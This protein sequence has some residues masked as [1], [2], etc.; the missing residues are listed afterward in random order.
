M[1]F[2]FRLNNFL[3]NISMLIII[4]GFFS[5]SSAQLTGT[6]TIPGDY[7]T[8]Q[9]A[10]ADLN[11]QGV[12]LGGVTFDVAAGHTETF[13]TD[14]AGNIFATGTLG[15][16]I[17]FQKSGV[18]NNPLITASGL[19]TISTSTS[20]TA[21]GDGII[22]IEG[23]DYITFDGIDLQENILATGNQFMEVGY[24]LK[25]ASG[26]DACKNVTI[27]NCNISLDQA[28]RY[29]YGIYV[30]NLFGSSTVTVTSIGGRSEDIKIY[31]N[32]IS[33]VYV[34]IHTRGYAAS[35]PYDLYD[36]NIEIGV[37][38]GNTITNF[39][40][41]ASTAYGM[42]SI[43]Q[44]NLKIANNT[45]NGG[46]G[47]TTTL[48]GIFNSTGTNS[49]LDVYGNTITVEGG[50]TT[51]S[52]Y[53]LSSSMGS[54]GTDNTVNIYDN[55][56]E[57]ST[58]PTAT[59]GA[60]YCLYNSASA[61][62]VNMYGNTVRNNVKDGTSG[63]MYLLYNLSTGAGGFANIYDNEIY[64][65]T[66]N[67]TG[68]LYCLYSNE[69][70]T[71]T[72]M[73]YGN[74]I[75]A[76]TG[77]GDVIGIFSAT[78]VLAHIYNNDIYDLTST[79]T[80]TASPYATGIQVSTGTDI[81]VYNNFISDLK[82]PAAEA[83]D[84][85]RGIGFTSATANATRNA[86]YNTVFLNASSTGVNFGSSGIFHIYSATAT[87]STLD[88]RNNNI[89]NSSTA[90]G[91]GVT[92]AFRRS[93]ATSLDNYSELSNNNNFYGGTPGVSNLLYYDGT[94]S[95]Q[96]IGDLQLLVGPRETASVSGNPPFV[97]TTTTPYDLHISTTTPTQL[98]SAG[99][100]ITSPIAVSTD[101][102]GDTRDAVFPDI[103]ADE[104]NGIGADLTS[105]SIT[106]D[107]LS[108]TANTTSVSLTATITDASG[109]ATGS[110]APRLYIK[111]STDLS[112]VF[113]D[114]PLVVG[115]D[116]T[117]T[118][119]YT[120]LGG[121]A[122][123]DVIEYYV[124]AQDVPG[125]VG[126]NPAGGSGANPPGTVPP[127][128][129][130]SYQIVD[131]PLN[132]TFTVG[133]NLFNQLTGKE[134][135]FETRTRTVTRD[136]NGIDGYV[137]V[138][139]PADEKSGVANLNNSP[140][141]VT[142]TE[143]YKVMMENG[144]PFDT[145][146]FLSPES[147]GVY[148]TITAAVN[149]LV[150]RGV[151]G[152][153]TFSLVDTDYPNETYPIDL[154]S[155][156]GASP[157]N[158]VTFK[159]ATGIQATIPGDSTQA[160]AT[161]RFNTSGYYYIIDGSNTVGGTSRDLTISVGGTA[162]SPAVHFYSDG[163]NN[164]V[165]NCIIESQNTSTGSG[166][167][168]LAAGDGSSNNVIDNCLF[169]PIDGASAYGIGV[170]MFSTTTS[171]NNTISNCE[172]VD[173]ADRGITM[174]GGVGV[175]NNQALYNTIY[176]TMP[177]SKTTIYGIY[178]GRGPDNIIEGN[179]IT[180]LQSSTSSP[181][182]AGIYYI[183]SSGVDMTVRVVNNVIAI[184][185]DANL[186]AGTIRGIDYF[187]YSAN[188]IEIYY[189]TVLIG[190]TDVTT[191]T[192]GAVNKRDAANNF[193]VKNNSFY[194]SRSNSSGTGIHYAVQF[195]NS[196]AT[197]FDLNNNDYYTSGTGGILGRWGTT[198]VL[199]LVDWQIATTMDA[200]SISADPLYSSNSDLRPQL[201]SPL[202]GAGV[203]VAGITT[204]V[205][206]VLRDIT[207]PTIGAYEEGIV[208]PLAGDYTVGLSL[209]RSLS[210]KDITFEKRV[211]TIQIEETIID[212]VK[213][214]QV[215][216]YEETVKG[217][218]TLQEPADA[219]DLMPVTVTRTVE[220]EYYVP[221]LNG[222]EYNG[223]LYYEFTAE[224]K[225]V[226]N[227]ESRGVYATITDA[228]ADATLKGVG[229]PVNFILVDATYPSETFPIV[230]GEIAGVSST[231]TITLRPNVGVTS[232]VSGTINMPIFDFVGASYFIIDGRSGGV[233]ED[234]ALTVENLSTVSGSHT[235]RLGGGSTFNTIRY[236]EIINSSQGTA[237]PR[238]IDIPTSPVNPLGNSFNTIEYNY[239]SGGRT[240]IGFAGTT[241]NPNTDNIIM[242][243]TLTDFAF[244]GIWFSSNTANTTVEGNTLFHTV[245][246]A[247]SGT[248]ISVGASANQGVTNIVGNHFYDL[249]HTGTGTLRGI[250][251]T[252]G[253]GSTFNLIN[254]FFSFT[255]DNG[256]K[257]SIYAVQLSGSTEYTV[258][259]YYNTFR[260]GGVH[261]GGSAGTI[262]T[263]GLVKSST[264][265]PA[266]F[267]AKNNIGL[268]ER[269]GGVEGGFHTNFFAGSTNLVG[270][271]D[272]DYN[273]W[274][275]EGDT[276]RSFSSGWA[277]FLYNDITDYKTAA[278]PHEQNTIFKTTEFVSLTDLH[279]AGNSVG[280]FDLI[281]YPIVGI[282]T[283]IDGQ[284][285][286][287]N[288][289]YRGADEGD[290]PLPVE[291]TSFAGAVSGNAVSLT[292]STATEI[293]NSG[294]E[295]QRK[296]DQGWEKIGFVD[297][298]GTTTELN[299]YSF[300][301][302]YEYVSF[303]GTASYRLKQIDF[304]GTF[305]YSSP[306]EVDVDFTPKDYTLY[307]NYPNPFN[308]STTIKYALPFDS[309][310]KIFIYNILGEVV[311]EL[312]NTV[313]GVGYHEVVL[314]AT[315]LA[316]GVYIYSIQAK[317]VD[318]G[319]D[320]SSVKKMMYLK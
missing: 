205:L 41:G 55:I 167:L 38:G 245:G 211:R 256:T 162:T 28:T 275:A 198:D 220:Q 47:T 255:Q 312:V 106:Y 50:A 241:A 149:D 185:A 254:N 53:G 37:D 152:P 304:D 52:I 202:I 123:G 7:A 317:S 298:K 122:I 129:P 76:N 124:A 228:I 302:K 262:V 58:Y 148:P 151:D 130:N 25:K 214:E 320:F 217:T 139:A 175:M 54:S 248:G 15:N 178:Q 177:S 45:I 144:K 263:A 115:D 5:L 160:A 138:N 166:S 17:I 203:P 272:I 267:N 236:T 145:N 18:G 133:L 114:S 308:P 65:N 204:D 83:T 91:T 23:G 8:I 176:Q 156:V 59:S 136:F 146:F 63:S 11:T 159:P 233:G 224:Q 20:L 206:G 287:I 108:N 154:T 187:G 318:G 295:V 86:Y 40:G 188:S 319:K 259:A 116:Y 161:I 104:F 43:Y 51:S 89:V 107:F 190:G 216:I 181:T 293:N 164:V 265:D 30:S 219:A 261:T 242:G 119:A 291:L 132:G 201:G 301:D 153:V 98:E 297:G 249:Q 127:P 280:D 296:L 226:N 306:V 90:N 292:W 300:S 285:R 9:A 250:T 194:N 100:P 213:E 191:G 99:T 13:T 70:S 143:T 268:N 142:V 22:I 137:D 294:F 225:A 240:G 237:G 168:I 72:K 78:G 29:S 14:S 169:R 110:N 174:Q 238:A 88:M 212:P 290:V 56:V 303:T 140:E 316:S 6:K 189:N 141:N 87:S 67:T 227:L 244:A 94:N 192:T 230:I 95:A 34:G 1:R 101:Y 69:V 305:A 266:I 207:T 16:E 299:N 307:Q 12:G 125:N 231:N 105:P 286:H 103:G 315:N 150:L 4:G 49:N 93:S 232:T 274:Y 179:I 210:G 46:A 313:Q 283:D 281:G 235:I 131:I 128:S 60:M 126:T 221:I 279:V 96:T 247:S 171:S 208:A 61:F 84:A 134:L 79:T 82:A 112:Y 111:K 81:Y 200:N 39:G 195:T 71:S 277:G 44:N 311:S 118:I 19:G 215:G 184:S 121:V 36:Q 309:N 251:G 120:T 27:R 64:G 170:Y 165:K 223:S 183:G 10:I 73:V 92:T 80:G 270:T 229:G 269:I 253:T 239:I 2:S 180:N 74:E 102:D 75:Y 264:G 109:V 186:T 289:P 62:N 155:V 32:N 117:F 314:N 246:Y 218:A 57:N 48:Y 284:T 260:F 31:N 197:L 282:T 199:T 77:G 288:F 273:V 257:S 35:T 3:F 163:S 258:N 182:I 33:N 135:Y 68:L 196:T 172:F 97:N 147:R 26:D 243:N 271:L 158:T 157:T 113:D 173:F 310:V 21:N 278:T 24:F 234:I 276:A 66:N 252:P 209:F 193:V 85:V 42:Y 222:I